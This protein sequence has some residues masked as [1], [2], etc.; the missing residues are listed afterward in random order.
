MTYGYSTPQIAPTVQLSPPTLP[1]PTPQMA[2]PSLPPAVSASLSIQE[3]PI[4][5]PQSGLHRISATDMSDTVHATTHQQE[6]AHRL[7]II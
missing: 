5:P 4:V 7:S 1:P 3:Y 6:T 2:F